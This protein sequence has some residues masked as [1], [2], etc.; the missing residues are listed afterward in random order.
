MK[1]FIRNLLLVLLATTLTTM[2]SCLDVLDKEPLDII[3]DKTVWSDPV[4]IESYL[5]ECYYQSSVFVNETPTYFS[6]YFWSFWQSE[7]GMGMHWINE[8]ADE[9]MANWRYNTDAA[10]IYKAGGLNSSGGLLEWWDHAYVIIRKLNEFLL[11]LPS[12]PIDESLKNQRMAEARFLRAFNYFAMVKRYGAVPLIT[13]PQQLDDPEE[14]LYA[15]RTSEKERHDLILSE[16][17]DAVAKG[18]APDL[19]DSKSGRPTRYAALAL[20]SRAAL[21]AGS[22]AQ[23]GTQQLDGLL[24]IPA[25]EAADYYRQSYNASKEIKKKFSL[26]NSD[27]DK[28]VNFKNIFLVKDNNEVIFAKKHN[29]Q[30]TSVDTGQYNG[31][32]C[33]GYDFAQCPKPHAWNAGNK[34]APY[35]EMAEEFEY[36]DGR[37]GTLNRQ[38]IMDG[39]WTTEELWGG[40]DPRF[41]ATIYTQNTDWKGT[42]VD[43]HNG[44]LLPNGQVL[45]SGSH[46]GVLAQGTQSVDN[47]FGTGFGVMKYLDESYN[48][49]QGAPGFSSTDYI[50]FRYGEILLNLAEAAYELN[51]SSEALSAINELRRRAGISELATIDR[52][53]I[54]HER[55]VELAFEGHR[56]WD[57]RRWRIATSALSQS[58][59]GLRYIQVYGT[60]PTQYKLEVLYNIDGDNRPQ[61]FEHQYYFPITLTRTGNNPNLV[62]NPGY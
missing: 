50:I 23:F 13:V 28:V 38:Q 42:K 60:N 16:I 4:L 41:F 39:T 21:Y 34:D 62:E 12:S 30:P 8:I 27:A 40:K 10:P 22:I 29:G 18:Y 37:P 26:Y 25:S 56:Y 9:A 14:E 24:G 44:L 15:P 54:R 58:Y 61:F 45:A 46:E 43:Y 31:G 11:R 19:A 59:S 53:K 57:V 17:A 49:L 1:K 7:A 55:K 52:D 20:I 3:S 6:E 2:T 32:S 51:Q 33:W 35:L 5:G 47:T 36:I 48:S